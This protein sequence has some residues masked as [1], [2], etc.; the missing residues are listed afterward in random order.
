MGSQT[1]R[2]LRNRKLEAVQL[3]KML[4]SVFGRMGWRQTRCAREIPVDGGNSSARNRC[5]ELLSQQFRR[6]EITWG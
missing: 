1:A 4:K 6:N 5:Q 3:T 2:A